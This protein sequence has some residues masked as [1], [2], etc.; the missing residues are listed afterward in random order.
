MKPYITYWTIPT[1]DTGWISEIHFNV[2]V[3]KNKL[4]LYHNY[5]YSSN[6]QDIQIIRK[7]HVLT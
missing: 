2:P 4:Y 1:G 6:T 7:K 3:Y 5:T